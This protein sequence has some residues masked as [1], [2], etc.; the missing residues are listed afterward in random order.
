[1]FQELLDKSNLVENKMAVYR[2]LTKNARTITE[3]DLRDLALTVSQM[4][5]L[6]IVDKQFLMEETAMSLYELLLEEDGPDAGQFQSACTAVV[7]SLENA[8]SQEELAVLLDCLETFRKL[9]GEEETDLQAFYTTLEGKLARF[10]PGRYCTGMFQR[11]A[12]SVIMRLGHFLEVRPV[13]QAL[14]GSVLALDALH[15]EKS[16]ALN[17]EFMQF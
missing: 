6:E 1:M 13:I 7:G 9:W 14:S 2:V 16:T 4:S 10:A 12:L 11:R 8:F 15:F 5:T 17:N 3:E